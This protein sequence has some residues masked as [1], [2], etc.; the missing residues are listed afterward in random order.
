MVNNVT[1][2][3]RLAGKPEL[4]QTPEGV[5]VTSFVVV[6]DNLTSKMTAQEMQTSSP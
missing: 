3:G 5:S 6:V 1:L 4:R 2:V